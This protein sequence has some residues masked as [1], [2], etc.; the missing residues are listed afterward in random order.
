M[1][2]AA[3]GGEDVQDLT[4]KRLVLDKRSQLGVLAIFGAKWFEGVSVGAI[5]VTILQC[6]ILETAE[7]MHDFLI[8]ISR[9]GDPPLVCRRQFVG[10]EEPVVHDKETRNHKQEPIAIVQQEPQWSDFAPEV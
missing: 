9:R 8:N 10:V 6:A 7:P 3:F 5:R 4:G 1:Q 2:L